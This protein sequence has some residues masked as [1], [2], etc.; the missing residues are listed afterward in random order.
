MYLIAVLV[1]LGTEVAVN[2]EIHSLTYIYTAL[3]K[4]V[5]LPGIH[6]FT[7]MGML[8]KRMIDYYDSEHQKKVPKQSWM[9]ERLPLDYWQKGT[10]S[11]LSKQQWFKVN[12]DIL[13]KRMNQTDGDVHVLQWLHGCEGK[14][15]T[16]G[17]MTFTRG[18][19]MYSYDGKDFLSFDDANA[20]WVAPVDIALP[21][22]RKWDGVQVLKEYTRGYLEN[23]CM[24]WLNKFV[25]YEENQLKK[26]SAP[27]VYMLAKNAR[28]DTNIILSCL[29]TG[30]YPKEITL[31]ITRNDRVLDI[32]DGLVSSGVRPNQ[33][34]TFQ[35]RDSIEIL[36][37]DVSTYK[38][39]VSH[40]ASNYS[41]VTVW[42][43]NI[44]NGNKDWRDLKKA[45]EEEKR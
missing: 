35:R 32:W 43:E 28:T 15:E 7:A 5:N 3:S 12:I 9:K 33:D 16:D 21:T 37:S 23:E 31:E 26:A 20:V 39:V 38:C 42:G 1:L 22:K 30:F 2:S 13:K 14:M 34:D 27:K 45:T 10:Q 17:S 19:D 41:S 6:E 4:P 18:M 29:A 44:K 40:R 11:R 8:D 25:V 36:R 24:D